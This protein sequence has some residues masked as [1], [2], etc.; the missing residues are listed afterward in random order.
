MTRIE[1][2]IGITTYAANENHEVTLPVNYIESVR[3]AGGIP[4]LL[5]PGE[6]QIESLLPHLSGLI[7]AGGGDIAPECYGGESHPLV[8]MVDEGRD[9]MELSLAREV[10]QREIPTLAICRGIQITNVALGGTLYPHLPD[11]FGDSIDHRNPP[12][13]PT[14]HRI[15]VDQDSRLAAIMESDNVETMSWHH[16]ALNQVADELHIVA[17]AADGVIEA[18]ELTGHPWFIGVQWHPELTSDQDPTQQNLFNEI[19]RQSRS[20]A[21]Q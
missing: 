2:L 14:P 4:V 20:T 18:V 16:Q 15:E 19:V 1:P 9:R 10:I 7:L 12:R 13:E 21:I 17:R 11:H 3:R 5:P 6:Q 8:Y